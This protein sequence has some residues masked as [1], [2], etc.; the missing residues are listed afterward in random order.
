VVDN[1]YALAQ[2]S[3]AL[4]TA[5][6]AKDAET[7]TR[8]QGRM[9][10][11]EQVIAGLRSGKLV[12]GSRT[13]VRDLPA[14]VTPEVVRGG[15][16]TG[17]PA[18][19][20]PLS[21]FER[22]L[23]R[24]AGLPEDRG[25]LFEYAITEPGMRRLWTVLDSGRFDIDLPEA[26]A[27]LVV[28]WLVREGDVDAAL[29]IVGELRPHA[30]TV[31]FLP[32]SVSVP[33]RDPEIV[34]REGA[35]SVA[36]ALRRKKPP[37]QVVRMNDVLGVWNPFADRLLEHWLEVASDGRLD[38]PFSDRW[39]AAGRELLA[40]F[41]RLSGEHTPPRRHM[42]PKENAT[43]LHLAIAAV[44]GGRELTAR[45]RGRVRAAVDAMV[46]RR[47]A[48]GTAAHTELRERQR[49]R[50]AMP[51]F[52]SLAHLAADRLAAAPPEAG[53]E[54][55]APFA[56]PVADAEATATTL[57][58]GTPMPRTVE[59][60][61]LRAKAGTLQQLVDE[62]V[63][64]SAE[65]LATMVPQL[66]AQV[67]AEQYDDP[68]LRVLMA[69]SYEAFRRRRS[70]LLLDLEHQVRPEELP[71]VAATATRRR[72][73]AATRDVARDTLLRLADEAITHWPGSILPNPLVAELG[74]LATSANLSV[75]LVEEIAADIFMGRFSKKY[76]EAFAL[77][78]SS[79]SG[80]LY[81]RYYQ[82][83]DDALARV[84]RAQKP[85]SAFSDL[86][87][88]RAQTPGHQWCVVCNGMVVEQS[89][90]LTTHNLASL[91]AIGLAPRE[92][93]RRAAEGA[94]AHAA[95]LLTRLKGNRRP[96]R[97]LKDLGYTWRQ[98]VFYL[99]QLDAPEQ[100]EFLAWA[101]DDAGR[102]SEFASARLLTL[103]N[104][105]ARPGGRSPLLGWGHGR[106]WLL[107]GTEEQ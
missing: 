92:G 40:E 89:Q 46:A 34:W 81:G 10:K 14:W 41:E 23:A 98:M 66:T 103:L 53:I 86:C 22:E 85:A 65:L 1:P 48:P 12:L 100:T 9:A 64:T 19:S 50:A 90:I 30:A 95:G 26:A 93:W 101:R 11:W 2:W 105:L 82:V 17:K 79:L 107:E 3:Q 63:I 52:A 94:Y 69:R 77:A 59:R 49:A 96:Q 78:A 29:S 47:G 6:T 70:L 25:A 99:A 75:P 80:T 88:D 76:A 97:M 83:S 84:R 13:P 71:W 58:V 45:E 36:A 32:A 43:V 44:V 5:A 31:R 73:T 61:L 7:R 21:R 15:F 57:P 18:A 8:A 91:V 51:T 27:L 39:L 62:A 55:V 24:E 56:A 87:N 104:D 102:R 67:V 33:E 106:H 74:T 20:G 60:A 37:A 38:E 16:A 72:A 54:D 4:L 28:A 35:G 68:V 42:S